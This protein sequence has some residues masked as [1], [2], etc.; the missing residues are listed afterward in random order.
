MTA[1]SSPTARLFSFV[2][3]STGPWLIE[4]MHCVVGEPIPAAG[5]LAILAGSSTQPASGSSWLLRGITSNE[6]YVTRQEK[7]ALVSKQEGLGRDRSE[8]RRVGKGW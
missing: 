3:G 1:A 5:R 4:H 8:E 7:G 6:R 2:G